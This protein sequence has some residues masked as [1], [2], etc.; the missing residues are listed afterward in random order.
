MKRIHNLG[1][2]TPIPADLAVARMVGSAKTQ[3]W[4]RLEK[5]GRRTARSAAE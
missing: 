3:N 1:R 5:V 4:L 2:L